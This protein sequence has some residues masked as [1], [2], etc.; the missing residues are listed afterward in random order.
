VPG[1]AETPVLVVGGSLVGLSTAALLGAHAVECLVVERHSGTAI[2]CC[3]NP[4]RFV[5]QIVL[6]FHA[7]LARSTF[8]STTLPPLR[9]KSCGRKA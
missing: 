4:S 7:W 1:R 5:A 2:R 3:V 8:A 9:S 6:R